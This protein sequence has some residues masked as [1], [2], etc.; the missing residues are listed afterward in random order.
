MPVPPV[1]GFGWQYCAS[2]M[3]YAIL[4]HESYARRKRP[5]ECDKTG[6]SR[7]LGFPYSLENLG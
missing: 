3:K 1:V 7:D 6:R 5:S 2:R 4:D